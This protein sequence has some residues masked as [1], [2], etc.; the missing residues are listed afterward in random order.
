MQQADREALA[1][2]HMSLAESIF[3]VEARRLGKGID[4]DELRSFAL[5]GLAQSIERWD[6]S[7]GVAFAV[8]A[9]QRIR[10][11]IYDGLAKS[12]WFPRRLHRKIAFFRR[13]SALVEDRAGDHVLSTDV[14]VV[15]ELADTLKELAV[16]Y[17]TCWSGDDRSSAVLLQD[18]PGTAEDM[19][20]EQDFRAK[21]RE[22]VESLPERQA[23]IVRAYFWQERSL[24]EI[25]I[26]LE[27]T[28]S[29]ASK[30]LRGALDTLSR[31]LALLER[32]EQ[33][34]IAP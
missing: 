1:R 3:Q 12:G 27:I 20:C 28:I 4:R 33:A 7:R 6:E 18:D 31:R 26:E 11:A 19:V 32:R 17:V 13:A 10:G 25:A 2:D 9:R 14:E 5:E 21:V 15:Q 24:S 22:M 8:F 16:A 23:H 30:L 34:G 29:W